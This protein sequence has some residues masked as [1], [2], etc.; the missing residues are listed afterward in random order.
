M[1]DSSVLVLYSLWPHSFLHLLCQNQ[2]DTEPVARVNL[3]V[4]R[5]LQLRPSWHIST[6]TEWMAIK[7]GATI[8]GVQGMIHNEFRWCSNLQP[9]PPPLFML[10][11]SGFFPC[12]SMF[13]TPN[14]PSKMLH[15]RQWAT[16]FSEVL[17]QE[18]F[19]RRSAVVLKITDYCV[20]SLPFSIVWSRELSIASY[21]G[22]CCPVNRTWG[23]L[24]ATSSRLK[25]RFV[26]SFHPQRQAVSD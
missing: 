10:P 8:V 18:A 17:F 19:S 26:A 6:L 2:V 5:L 7:F 1:S 13:H 16:F 15:T 14:L 3:S 20:A 24:T 22:P 23:P 4:G 21:S 9:V 25:M 12:A 11:P